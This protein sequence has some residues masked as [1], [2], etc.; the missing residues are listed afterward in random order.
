MVRLQ[1]CSP[2][3]GLVSASKPSP[4]NAASRAP[5]G[6]IFVAGVGTT[7]RVELGSGGQG[8]KGNNLLDTL[9]GQFLGIMRM[10]LS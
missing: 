10:P 3:D 8:M 9:A 1:G 4:A 2:D 5:R 6:G 7:V